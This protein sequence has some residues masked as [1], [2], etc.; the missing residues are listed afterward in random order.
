MK[1]T[2]LITTLIFI[3]SSTTA[4]S[5]YLDVSNPQDLIRLKKDSLL[6]H[7]TI[8]LG[9]WSHGV[10]TYNN[11]IPDLV[12]SLYRGFAYKLISLESSLLWFNYVFD[13]IESY[14]QAIG[15]DLVLYFNENETIF[16]NKL[17]SYFGE[18]I[19]K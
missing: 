13:E 19:E 18:K 12:L 5:K 9:E 2:L 3:V 1:N 7:R 6:S 11:Y 15:F 14:T 8:A 17:G 10:E 4:Q 16:N